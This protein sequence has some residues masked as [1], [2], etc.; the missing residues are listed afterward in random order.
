MKV[1]IYIVL[2]ILLSSCNKFSNDFFEFLFSSK[3]ISLSR[4]CENNPSLFSEGRSF[5]SYSLSE[6]NEK[7]ALRGISNK[8]DFI[9]NSKYSRYETP[10][11][12]KTPEVDLQENVYS[13]IHSEMND[14]KNK[15]FEENDLI[16]VLQ[17][18]DNYYTFLKDDVG[19]SKLFILDTHKRKL[20]LLTSYE[21]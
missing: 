17:E 8:S 2:V 7:L 10:V 4:D 9:K 11:W 1:Y 5:E 18:K 20:Y 3:G 6:Q 12:R 16:K 14:E 19:R 15:C 13:F 21:L